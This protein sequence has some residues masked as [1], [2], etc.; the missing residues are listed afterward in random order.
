VLDWLRNLLGPATKA[1][2]A[3][4]VRGRYDAAQTTDENT[5][6]WQLTDY[7]SP[8]AANNFAVRRTLRTRSRYEIANNPYARG[9]TLRLANDLVGTGPRLHIDTDDEA[10]NEQVQQAWN[11]WA[12]A[13][14]L[15]RKLRTMKMAKIQDGEAFGVLIT[16]PRVNHSVKLDVNLVEA[17]Q[18]T[19]PITGF[20]PENWVDGL[21]LDELGNVVAYTVLDH[22][23][24]DWVLPNL[25]P[26][27]YKTLPARSVLHIFREDRAGQVRGIPEITPAL[28]LFAKLRDFGGAVLSA[29]KS[30]A[31]VGGIFKTP[32]AAEVDDEPV[33][34][35]FEPIQFQRGTWITAPNGSDINQLKAEQPTTTYDMFVRCILRE[36]GACLVVPF[37]IV[38]GDSSGSNFSSARMDVLGYNRQRTVERSEWELCVL[39]RIFAAFLDE[40]VMI[41]GLL[42]GGFN[43][44]DVPH[45][46]FWDS[47]E[48]IDP[49][50]D[51]TAEQIALAANTTTLKQI[52]AERGQDWKK[53]VKQ[54]GAE[55]E[56]LTSEGVIPDQKTPKPGEPLQEGGKPTPATKATLDALALMQAVEGLA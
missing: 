32:A 55:V 40:A 28:E 35:P 54:R 38:A 22:H 29:A 18:V 30:A 14:Y 33:V 9:M 24:G 27:S 17:D 13:I 52:F 48:S 26:L 23:P 25:N 49:V 31:Y 11:S 10:A 7:L 37:V 19:T 41:P 47:F 15:G 20:A 3:S 1:T 21:V 8:K 56:L 36:I 4:Q 50:K 34:K 51:A 46:W 6:L 45:S 42:P 53:A 44:S 12:R 2:A 16:N 5:P 39:D 43:I